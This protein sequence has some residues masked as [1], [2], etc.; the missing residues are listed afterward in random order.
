MKPGEIASFV[1]FIFVF[2]TLFF[3]SLMQWER[4]RFIKGLQRKKAP[5]FERDQNVL[6]RLKTSMEINVPVNLEMTEDRRLM[7]IRNRANNYRKLWLISL[8]STFV[9][10]F[11]IY[12]LLNI[13]I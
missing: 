8:I 9:A 1:F 11:L 6:I 5:S 3:Q 10:P 4:S 13:L 12:K 7:E 2:I